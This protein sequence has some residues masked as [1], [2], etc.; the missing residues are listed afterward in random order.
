MYG[1]I[2]VFLRHFARNHCFFL[3]PTQFQRSASAAHLLPRGLLNAVLLWAIRLSANPIADSAYSE[4]EVLA[5]TVHHVASDIATVE[6][7][8]HRAL[9]LIQ[10]EILLSL[11]YLDC[12][13]FLEGNYHRA[14]AT[15]LAFT[16]VL[17]LHPISI[18]HPL[19]RIDQ[20][21]M[22]NAFSKYWGV[23]YRYRRN[24]VTGH[25]PLTL[26]TKAS[27]HLERAFAFSAHNPG[28]PHPPEFWLPRGARSKCL[29]AA[30]CVAVRLADAHLA[31]WEN[32]DPV[33]GP[34]LA[35]VADVLVVNIP[36]DPQ[37]TTDMQTTLSALRILARWSPLIQQYSAAVQQRYR[38][39]QQN[40]GHFGPV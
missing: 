31:E 16:A 34:L 3:D 35:A 9:H 25:S 39:A 7:S 12:G 30:R 21:S 14:A 5:Q 17:W 19:R 8:P 6:A 38:T 28:L 4:V 20:H 36:H 32:A 27:I 11:Y 23:R 10:A 2:N 33:F 40:L 18:L 22:A 29:F 1:S 15:S 24:D 13:R 37:A 26:L